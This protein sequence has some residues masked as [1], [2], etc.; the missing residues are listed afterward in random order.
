MRW[1]ERSRRAIL[2]PGDRRS[3][4]QRVAMASCRD[5]SDGVAD[6]PRLPRKVLSGPVFSRGM[7]NHPGREFFI[8]R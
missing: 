8:L 7:P 1:P 5:P 3:R 2:E 6:P 4:P